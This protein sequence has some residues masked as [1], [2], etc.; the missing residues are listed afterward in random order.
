MSLSHLLIRNALVGGG[1]RLLTLLTGMVLTPYLL[2]R[3]GPDRFGIWA[4]LGVVT[5]MV[6]LGDFSFRTTLVR[7]LASALA[8]GDRKDFRTTASTGIAFC[9]ANALALGFLLWWSRD[10]VL[11]LLGIP[12]LLRHEAS[13]TFALGVG[14]QLAAISLSVFPALCDARQRLD[15]TN[16]LGVLSLLLGA[17]LTVAAVESGG[18]LVGAAAAQLA[19]TLFFY[20][21]ALGAA[22][23][24]FGNTGISP[25]MVRAK[26]LNNLLAFGMTLHVSTI[27]GII[28]RQFDKFLLSRRAGLGWVGSCELAMKWV[29]SAG[30]FQPFLAATLLPAAS[31]L[32]AAGELQRLRSLY[33]RAYRYLFLAGLPPFFFLAAHRE[34]VILAWLGQADHRAGLMILLLASGYAVNS[35]S[36]GMAYVCQGMGRP[37]I[38][39]RQ[40]VIQLLLNVVLSILLF[41]RFGPPGAVAGTSLA[42][43]AG[44]TVFVRHFHR[45]LGIRTLPLLRDTALVP[46]LASLAAALASCLWLSGPAPGDRW[47][48]LAG[49]AGAGLVF[50]LVFTAVCLVSGH[51]GRDDWLLLR[52]AW[53]RH[54]EVKQ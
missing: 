14:G 54:R 42:L 41:H 1:A 28:N 45:Y 32:A 23:L 8:S 46:L 51:L 9:S 12:L 53:Q 2:L 24:L 11:D 21:A 35:L 38:Q 30:T 26:Q 29:A 36:N 31:Q 17:I 10:L 33:H 3:L 44:A 25:A 40:S 37:D 39:A 49:L 18:G 20:L 43:L 47:S 19:S 50:L 22:R 15:V 6:A 7:E 4:L 48:A 5:G 52:S 16:G 13:L 27:C 34:T